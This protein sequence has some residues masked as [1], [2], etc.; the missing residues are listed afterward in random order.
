MPFFISKKLCALDR[1]MFCKGPL[2]TTFLVFL[3]VDEVCYIS[4][5]NQPFSNNLAK[6][7]YFYTR[8]FISLL[9]F[10][11]KLAL[12]IAK[13]FRKHP[14]FTTFSLFLTVRNVC[15]IQ[16]NTDFFIN[17]LKNIFTQDTFSPS[18]DSRKK[19]CSPS[20]KL[21]ETFLL[22]FTAFYKQ[23]TTFLLIFKADEVCNI[24]NK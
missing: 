20:Q 3:T 1:R 18:F 10:E 2:F 15:N 9:H 4:N 24:S 23:F 8:D 12:F 5:K 21:L 17:Q 16:I 19:L 14:L 11:R 6:R 7:Q 22:H 13:P